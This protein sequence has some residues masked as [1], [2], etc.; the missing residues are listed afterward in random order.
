MEESDD[1][2][3]Y[4]DKTDSAINARF[5]YLDS[6]SIEHPTLS[7][8]FLKYSKDNCLFVNASNI[9][10][11]RF[12][13]P[14]RYLTKRGK[15]YA[16]DRFWTKMPEPYTLHRD[17]ACFITDYTDDIMRGT[18]TSFQI[19]PI[20]YLDEVASNEEEKT[21]A[22]TFMK[23]Y[24]DTNDKINAITDAKKKE[25][26]IKKTE[27]KLKESLERANAMLNTAKGQRVINEKI[28]PMVLKQELSA[29]DSVGATPTIKAYHIIKKTLDRFEYYHYPLSQSTIDTLAA[30][31]GPTPLFQSVTEKNNYYTA[32]INKD[33]NNIALKNNKAV[34]GM[35]EGEDIL[36]KLI[37]PY[38][39]KY[40]LL[41]VWGTWCG[42][43]KQALSHSKEEYERLAKYNIQYL[44]LANNSPEDT[45]KTVIKEYDVTGDNVTHYNLPEE[46]QRAVEAYIGLKSYPT[47]KL[48]DPQGRILDVKVDT[49]EL[50]SLEQLLEQLTREDGTADN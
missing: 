25:H 19:N 1:L 22:N 24:K 35:K 26:V 4:I 8:R 43:C 38:R 11:A 40:I 7:D 47:F 49:R 6:I 21:F 33:F 46:Q 48:I 37:E 23:L 14:D 2:D 29:L 16:Y 20:A 5:A 39:G 50:N 36:Q 13:T 42:P 41:D 31:T 12:Y 15:Q 44:Y 10:Q 34:E 9:G 3:C 30:M 17:L 28:F 18:Q 32:L 27:N 45:W